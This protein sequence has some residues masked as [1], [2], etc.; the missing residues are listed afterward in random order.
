M[1]NTGSEWF[2]GG[3]VEVTPEWIAIVLTLMG[4][5]GGVGAWLQEQRHKSRAALPIIRV[6]WSGGELGFTAHVTI[7]NRLNEDVCVTAVEC[8]GNFSDVNSSYDTET[9]EVKFNY[10]PIPSPQILDWTVPALGEGTETFTVDGGETRRWLR[11]TLSSSSK[12]LRRKR[13]V[14]RESR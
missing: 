6:R 2:D 12:T 13:M 8:V 11:L 10:T 3:S 14:V 9:S 5:S 7:I 4:M 1:S